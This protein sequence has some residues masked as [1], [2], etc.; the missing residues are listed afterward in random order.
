MT[1]ESG[2]CEPFLRALSDKTRWSI[3]RELLSSPRT[4]SDLAERLSVSQPNVSKHVRIL[5]EAG[6]IE[7]I[8]RGKN[9]DCRIVPAFQRRVAKNDNRL[10]LGCCVFRF[11][12][13]CC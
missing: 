1:P 13:G 7:T 8:K 12:K 6:I 9:V 10:D 3:V 5:R 4:V 2:S 11:G